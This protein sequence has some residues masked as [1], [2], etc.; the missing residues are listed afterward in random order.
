MYHKTKI[1][2]TYIR[3]CACKIYSIFKMPKN[4]ILSQ[5]MT[6]HEKRLCVYLCKY[7]FIQYIRDV[8]MSVGVC[9]IVCVF[10]LVY[11]K[12]HVHQLKHHINAN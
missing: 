8:Y 10:L 12:V 3:L 1:F 7:L 4:K 5:H 2:S 11:I 6:L 9:V